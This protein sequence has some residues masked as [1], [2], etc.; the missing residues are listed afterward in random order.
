MSVSIVC[1]I[2]ICITRIHEFVTWIYIYTKGY[3]IWLEK[4]LEFTSNFSDGVGGGHAARLP[5]GYALA[6]RRCP[7]NTNDLATPLIPVSSEY[8]YSS[9]G[10][11]LGW[12]CQVSAKS[13]SE[14]IYLKGPVEKRDDNA[15]R[16]EVNKEFHC[17]AIYQ[18]WISTVHGFNRWNS[19]SSNCTSI[20]FNSKAA[21]E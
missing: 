13:G 1:N 15:K 16:S 6:Y 20:H 19:E 11:K 18:G 5:R 7:A 4:A 3:R 8:Y 14:V 12:K 17:V 9:D 10:G 2:V 21:P